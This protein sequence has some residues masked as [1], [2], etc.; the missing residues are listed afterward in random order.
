[1]RDPGRPGEVTQ[2]RH[3]RHHGRDGAGQRGS[4]EGE[5]AALAHPGHRDPSTVDGRVAAQHLDRAHGVGV[6]P[7][8]VVVVRVLDAAGEEARLGGTGPPRVAGVADR[9]A[10]A[11]AAGVD[12]QVGVAGAGPEDV[13]VGQTPTAVVPLELH[14]ARQYALE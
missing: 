12:D 1:G 13:L 5:T 11:L 2:E 4:G 9:P 6:D 3:I 7:P 8:V 14:H 10:A